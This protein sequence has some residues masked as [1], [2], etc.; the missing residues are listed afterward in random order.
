VITIW[1]IPGV[2]EITAGDDL[3][4]EIVDGCRR[5]G[6]T[7][8]DGDIVVV[9]HK[10]V[11]K[12]EGRT[13]SV[14]SDAD[15][16]ALVESQ[17]AD[18]IRRRGDLVITRTPHGFICANAAVDRS[19]TP[20]G[21][22]VLLPDDPDRSAHRLRRKLEQL[23]GVRLGVVI[24]DTFGRAWRRGQTDVAIGISGVT[25]VL[26]LRGSTDHEGRE[27]NATEPAVADELAGAA[28]LVM[29]KANR[30]PIA[31]VRGSG[32]LGDGRAAELVR[33]PGE[34]LFL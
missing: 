1:P 29:G 25:A 22:A 4:T 10:V 6:L 2:P 19:N 13:A 16:R 14:I 17:A 31:V 7:L 12:A 15:Y 23:T 26:D 20:A 34:D 8:E 27:L 32:L 21:T 24:T 30:V 33:D 9:T 11:S 28:D 18:I 5:A 3:A